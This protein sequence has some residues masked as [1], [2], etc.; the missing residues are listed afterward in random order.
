MVLEDCLQDMRRFKQRYQMKKFI[1]IFTDYQFVL[2]Q[3]S[4][5][6]YPEYQYYYQIINHIFKVQGLIN[7]TKHKKWKKSMI[8]QHKYKCY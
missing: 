4:I 6:G 3:L 7:H 1:N 2:D 5:N 8:F